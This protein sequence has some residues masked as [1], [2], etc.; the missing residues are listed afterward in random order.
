MVSIFSLHKVRKIGKVPITA[1]YN[2]NQSTLYGA[3]CSNTS[4]YRYKLQTHTPKQMQLQLFE[5]RKGKLVYWQA[6]QKF[7]YWYKLTR[8]NQ[9]RNYI[10][11]SQT[12]RTKKI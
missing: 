8:L 6:L 7:S 10:N 5:E 1:H 3:G 11:V 12:Y 2:E 4:G 9:E